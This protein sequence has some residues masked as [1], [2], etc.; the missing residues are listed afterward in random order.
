MDEALD[1]FRYF[2]RRALTFGMVAVITPTVGMA[3]TWVLLRRELDSVETSAIGDPGSISQPIGEVLIPA[4]IG[5]AVAIVALV[6][7][8]TCIV[9]ALRERRKLHRHDIA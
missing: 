3:V 1:R 7:C 4:L 2:W 6:L 8:I 5:L 9:R